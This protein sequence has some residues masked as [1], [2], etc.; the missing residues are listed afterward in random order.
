M[1]VVAQSNTVIFPLPLSIE[2]VSELLKSLMICVCSLLSEGMS[3]SDQNTQCE[4][5]IEQQAQYLCLF[6]CLTFKDMYLS[7]LSFFLFYPFLNADCGVPSGKDIKPSVYILSTACD[8]LF[9]LGLYFIKCSY[10]SWGRLAPCHVSNK[11]LRSLKQSKVCLHYIKTTCADPLS[12][13]LLSGLYERKP[14]SL[15]S[16]FIYTRWSFKFRQLW[17]L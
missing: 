6:L 8:G 12:P 11:T 4:W 7:A 13:F 9:W 5:R 17:N 1:D 16:F 2:T 15:I 10:H 14:P 3:K